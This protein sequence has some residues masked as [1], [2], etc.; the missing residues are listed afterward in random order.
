MHE[1]EAGHLL[2]L[3]PLQM[4]DEV[5]T[6]L[7]A[8]RIH[9]PD[10]LLDP[11]L[12]DVPEPCGARRLHCFGA[13]S[14]RHGDHRDQLFMAPALARGVDTIPDLPRAIRQVR[15]SHNALSYRRLHSEASE[16]LCVGV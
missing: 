11:V 1:G 10:C 13:V 14:L 4:S 15:K 9:L 5:P 2:C 3:I 7:R 16:S 8:D 12:T 6:D